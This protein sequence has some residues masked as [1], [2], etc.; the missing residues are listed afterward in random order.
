MRLFFDS[1]I[2]T[3]IAIF[4]N[5]FNERTE[6]SWEEANMVWTQLQGNTLDVN[7]EREIQALLLIYL[8]DDKAHFD[9]LCSDIA[10]GE[11]SRISDVTKR[12][13]HSDLIGR[14]MEHRQNVYE[15]EERVLDNDERDNIYNA[16]LADLPKRMHDDGRQFCEALVVDADYFITNDTEFIKKIKDY[17]VAQIAIKASDIPFVRLALENGSV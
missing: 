12:Y 15:E 11:I 9:W 1:N 7:L 4:E 8:I 3:Y 16:L 14:L 5:F 17:D 10:I 6:S 2:L 13:W